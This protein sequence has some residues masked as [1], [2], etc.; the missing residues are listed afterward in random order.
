MLNTQICTYNLRHKRS[1]AKNAEQSG[2][3]REE[4]D[5][6]AKGRG[7]ETVVFYFSRRSA[8][9]RLVPCKL[10]SKQRKTHSR[11]CGIS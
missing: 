4:L 8:T 11:I 3:V 10:G 9:K 7:T 1:S 5:L 2:C 6:E